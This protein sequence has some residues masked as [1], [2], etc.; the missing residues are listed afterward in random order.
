M[1]VN[2]YNNSS[3]DNISVEIDGWNYWIPTINDCSS[4]Q[5]F[6]SDV[7]SILK[8]KQLS[9]WSQFTARRWHIRFVRDDQS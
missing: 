2:N 5:K 7:H 8:C 9:I 4:L 1:D 6:L 3:N